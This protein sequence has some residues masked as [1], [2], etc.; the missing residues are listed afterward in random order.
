MINDLLCA[1]EIGR[2]LV[3][4][5]FADDHCC[6]MFKCIHLDDVILHLICEHGMNFCISRIAVMHL[7]M[8]RIRHELIV[9]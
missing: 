4:C 8:L 3:M 7:E 9:E 5:I 1:R 6:I 2:K